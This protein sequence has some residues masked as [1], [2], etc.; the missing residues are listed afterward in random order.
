[1][2]LQ[3]PQ[4]LRQQAYI[5][6]HWLS[7]EDHSRLSVTNPATGKIIAHVPNLGAPET[8][9]AIEAAQAAWP[10]WRDLLAKERAIILRRW[11]ELITANAEDLALLMTIEQG[12]PLPEAQGEVLYGA[13]FV[14]WYAEEAKRIYGDTI[15]TFNNDR[16]ILVLKQPIGVVA[17][18]TP[19]NFPIAMITR[20]CAPA[21][22]AGCPVVIKPAEST[23]L[24]ALALA[25]LAEQAGFPPGVLNVITG[26]PAPIGKELTDN[27]LIRKLSFTGST[28][29][30]KLLMRQCADTV[31]QQQQQQQQQKQQQQQQ[32]RTFYC[33]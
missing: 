33:I 5:N 18:I 22:A 16:R 4:L 2:Q 32:Q 23:P 15:P 20:K 9:L 30:G 21:L 3:N 31:K 25:V 11:Y 6:G 8:R 12:K 7:A 1:M 29:T 27:P 10:A 17:A 14:E 24:S 19:W 26:M 13:S 28:T